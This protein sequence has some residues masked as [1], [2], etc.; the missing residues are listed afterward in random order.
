MSEIAEAVLFLPRSKEQNVGL[1]RV[2]CTLLGTGATNVK[3]VL[4]LK[5][6]QSTLWPECAP[7]PNAY[8]EALITNVMYLEVGPVG[9]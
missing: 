1:F 5:C 2:P 3:Y 4:F 7:S 6:Q 9:R 8:V